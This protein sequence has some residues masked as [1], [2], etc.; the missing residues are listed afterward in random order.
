MGRTTRELAAFE[1]E[2]AHSISR[3]TFNWPALRGV[4]VIE[5]PLLRHRPVESCDVAAVAIAH[6]TIQWL[7][8]SQ[9]GWS[10][11]SRARRS[12]FAAWVVEA[13]TA[14]DSPPNICFSTPAKEPS[15]STYG[16]QRARA[17]SST[18]PAVAGARATYRTAVERWPRCRQC[19]LLYAGAGHP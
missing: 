17:S 13:L 12:S 2:P 10:N 7:P 6:S 19:E 15:G 8:P 14:L 1:N 11:T 16:P 5:R 18:L 4:E 9:S 3:K